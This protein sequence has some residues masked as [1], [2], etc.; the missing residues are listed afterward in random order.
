MKQI[1]RRKVLQWG[2]G[3]GAMGVLAACKPPHH[4][5]SP[6]H[7]EAEAA[8]DHEAA[9]DDDHV[10]DD[11]QHDDDH[12]HHDDDA[13]GRTHGPLARGDRHGRW[14]RRKFAR[15]PLRRLGVLQP[16]TDRLDSGQPGAPPQQP[17]RAPPQPGPGVPPTARGGGRARPPEPRLLTLGDAPP[18]VVRRHRRAPIPALRVPRSS[19]RRH[20][21]TQRRR[22]RSVARLGTVGVA[23][24]AERGHVVDGSLRRRQLPRLRR[25]GHERSVDR[26]APG[27]EPGGSRR[28]HHA[29]RRAHR[30]PHRAAIQ[31]P[32]HCAAPV[33]DR[34]PRHDARGAARRRGAPDPRRCGHPHRARPV[35]RRLRHP[36]GPPARVT[37]TS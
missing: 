22:H 1:P 14:P 31:R 5:R 24:G 27:D 19:V 30:H 34:V 15:H 23:R 25:R 12:D 7:D 33:D 3:A 9:G 2:V 26:R 18:L 11:H 32:P 10:D 6:R 21:D 8:D 13:A 20:R 16:P 4:S 17:V 28:G 37:T 36:R 29:L 35:Q